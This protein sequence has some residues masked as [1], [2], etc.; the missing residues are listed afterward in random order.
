MV[1]HNAPQRLVHGPLTRRGLLAGCGALAAGMMLGRGIAQAQTMATGPDAALDRF[2]AEQFD[3]DAARSPEMRTWLGLGGPQDGWDDRSEAALAENDRVLAAALD[4]LHRDFPDGG[5][6]PAGR[7]NKKLW[8]YQAGEKLAAARWRG[9][10]YPADH[11][12]GR[13]GEIVD[14]LSTYHPVRDGQGARAWIAR[15]RSVGQPVGHL[16]Q[17]LEERAANGVIPPRFSVEKTL[18]AVRNV[19]TG[20]PFQPDAAADSALLAGFARK[21]ADL[22]LP[23]AEKQDLTRQASGALQDAF[24]PAWQRLATSLEGLA[25]RADDRDGVWKLPDGE[26]YYRWCLRSHTTLELEPETVHA[27]GLQE[28]RR[29][30]DEMAAI[31]HKVG[32]T[33][34]MAAFNRFLREEGRF[35]FPDTDEGHAA[36]INGATHILEKVKAAL[37]GQFNLKPK[38]PLVVQR[39]ERYREASET[40]ARYSPPASDGSRP[41]IYYVNL[42]NMKEMPIWQMEVLAF[43]EGIPGHHMQIALAQEATNLP[44]FRRHDMHTAYVEGWGLYSER[45]PKELGFY[46]DPYSDF[47]RLTFELWRA[48]RLVLD[49][50]IHVKKWSRQQA[51]DYFTRNTAFTREVAEREVDRYIVYPGQACAYY[52]GLRKVLEL[53]EKAKKELGPSFDM[54]GFHDAILANG[55]VPL[56]VLEQVVDGWINGRKA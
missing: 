21:V 53:R 2:F 16:I 48:I 24:A 33:G 6:T 19:L 15:V 36:Y 4:R 22:P 56:S 38:A 42:S 44:A 8:E 43:H 30:Q 9:N 39:F 14:L 20:R 3:A 41:G 40:I 7:L 26:D 17:A 23:E 11:F 34:D 32:F 54:K 5:L 52:I 29:I 31:K 18:G 13:H 51:I 47:G 12:N 1:Q 27:L 55:S 10:S 49:T 50:G 46:E 37:D 35:Y 25:A 45:L 28:V